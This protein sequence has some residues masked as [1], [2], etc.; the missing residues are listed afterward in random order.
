M[1]DSGSRNEMVWLSGVRGVR[2]PR[3]K[4][5][6]VS[7]VDVGTERALQ[8]YPATGARAETLLALSARI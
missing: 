4:G 6:V 5:C 8:V 2:S 7:R 1:H 3:G